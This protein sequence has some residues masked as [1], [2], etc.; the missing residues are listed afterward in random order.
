M[1]IEVRIGPGKRKLTE[2]ILQVNRLSGTPVEKMHR[3]P[4][5]SLYGSFSA[6]YRQAGR[7]KEILHSVGMNYSLLPYVIDGF[8][9]INGR[10]D[11]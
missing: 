8:H 1:L 4:R 9:W 3:V 5:I 10:R 7:V 2:S 6:D 11:C